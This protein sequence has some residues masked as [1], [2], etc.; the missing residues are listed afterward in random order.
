MNKYT[1]D[2]GYEGAMEKRVGKALGIYEELM[3]E[4]YI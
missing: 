4:G 1:W 3:K 2:G